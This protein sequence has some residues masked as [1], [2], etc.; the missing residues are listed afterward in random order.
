MLLPGSKVDRGHKIKGES[1]GRDWLNAQAHGQHAVSCTQ[2]SLIC[3]SF[4][5][6]GLIRF[7]LLHSCKLIS[8]HEEQKLL[9]T[10]IQGGVFT[11]LMKSWG[12]CEKPWMSQCLCHFTGFQDR[13]VI[14][15]V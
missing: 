8:T 10:I 6:V 11:L 4:C 2:T 9:K 5:L 13:E 1:M 14:V 3:L 7:R 15:L 12:F